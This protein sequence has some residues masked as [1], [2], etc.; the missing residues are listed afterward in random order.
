VTVESALLSASPFIGQVCCLGDARPYTVA[1]I[2]LDVEYV[3][4]WARQE[5]ILDT[6]LASLA[7]NEKVRAHVAAGVEAG[8]ARLNRPEQI[9]KFHIVPG[10]WLPGRELTP[11][12]K[13]RRNVIAMQYRDVI[14]ELYA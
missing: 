10:E 4:E 3:T 9:K 13:M 2:V 12:S 1:L 5:G 7:R 6:S 8:N 11:T 14:E